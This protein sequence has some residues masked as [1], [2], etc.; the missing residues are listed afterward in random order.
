MKQL[1]ALMFFLVLLAGCGTAEQSTQ[2]SQ[3]NDIQTEEG[4]F[5]GLADSHTIEVKVNNEP[6]SLIIVDDY[7]GDIN[8]LK[9]GEK[10]KVNYQKNE[11]GQLELKKIES[12]K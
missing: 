4:T 1:A 8:Q 10:V 12:I 6:V 7:K 5:V 2:G 3:T 11:E 9:D